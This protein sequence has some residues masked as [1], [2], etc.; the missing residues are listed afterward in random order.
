MTSSPKK[1][2]GAALAAVW[3][4]C[5]QAAPAQT[6]SAVKPAAIHGDSIDSA[7]AAAAPAPAPAKNIV[8]RTT[9]GIIDADFETLAA[10]TFNVPDMTA[11]NHPTVSQA[12]KQI[13]A[14]IKNLEGK[15]VH[16][17]GF[18]M[19][20]KELQGKTTEFMIMRGQPSCC[21][22]GA[23]EINEFVTVKVPAPGFETMMD[24]PVTIEG[25]LHVGAITDSSFIVGLYQLDG[26]KLIGP[27]K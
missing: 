25:K 9:G 4:V 14:V 27:G 23:T 15:T 3:L 12:E 6:N 11:A 21:F 2:L 18:M 10:F 7:P 13:P 8:I 26:E 16:I 22:S 5:A 20:V 1:I 17:K 19:P 24:D